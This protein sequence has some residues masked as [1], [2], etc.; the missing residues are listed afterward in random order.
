MRATSNPARPEH[1][2]PAARQRSVSRPRHQIDPAFSGH[3]GGPRRLSHRRRERARFDGANVTGEFSKPVPSI[4]HDTHWHRGFGPLTFPGW[5]AVTE[6]LVQDGVGRVLES[7]QHGDHLQATVNLEQLEYHSASNTVTPLLRIDTGP[8]VRIQTVGAK[9]SNGKLRQLIPV[10]QERTVDRGLL[11][12][13]RRNLIDYFQSKGYF[14]AQADFDDQQASGGEQAINYRVTLG[15]RHRLAHIA[16]SGNHYFDYDM[17]RERMESIPAVSRAGVSEIFRSARSITTSRP[18]AIFIAPTDFAMPK[19][20][21][22]SRM[23]IAACAIVWASL[24]RSTKARSGSL[25]S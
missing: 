18:F 1:G 2:G 14:D 15:A 22:V 17:L 20:P 23:P 4:I 9:V 12:E 24:F 25:V 7:L 3:R 10:Y 19:S 21:P 6:R 8:I 11:V 16:I 5:R 13:G